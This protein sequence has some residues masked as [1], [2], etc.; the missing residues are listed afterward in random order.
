MTYLGILLIK[1][2]FV[3][4]DKPGTAGRQNKPFYEQNF[5]KPRLQVLLSKWDHLAFI[6]VP[7]E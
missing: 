5:S 1:H 4:A 3:T 2:T 7:I 6:L